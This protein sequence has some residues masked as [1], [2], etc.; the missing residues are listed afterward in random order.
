MIM[1][2]IRRNLEFEQA[3]EVVRQ[4]RIESV[5]QYIAWHNLNKPAGLPK[6]PDRAYHKDFISW[7]DFLGNTNPFPII[8]KKYRPFNEA[9]AFAQSLGIKIKQEW[10][11]ACDDGKTANDIPRRPDLYYRKSNEWVS[12]PNF[13]GAALQAKEATMIETTPIFFIIHNPKADTGYFRC[14]VT[15]GGVSSINDFLQS[16]SGRLVVAYH[17][18]QTF[19]VNTFLK[20]FDVEEDRE[21]A[22]YY[23]IPKMVIVLSELSIQFNH[24][25]EKFSN[26]S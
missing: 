7:N 10:L 6:R 13:L 20:Q 3:R 1:A 12:W 2:R 5:A 18:P 19:K 16:V 22:G 17:V 9:R 11:D 25:Y 15:N 24:V 14:G 21:Y 4:E 26:N 8:R 23:Y